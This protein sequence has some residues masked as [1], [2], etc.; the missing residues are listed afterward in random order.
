MIERLRH[1]LTLT[2]VLYFAVGVLCLASPSAQAVDLVPFVG[3]RFG[4]DV[5][6]TTQ[7]AQGPMSVTLDAAASYGGVIDVPLSGPRSI[8]FYY[9]RQQTTLGSPGVAQIHD[10]TM[11]VLHIGLV[12][13]YATDNPQLT[14][15][16]AGTF[17]ATQLTAAGSDETK[18]SIGLGGGVIWMANDHIGIR[19]DLRALLTF[20]GNG[21][22]AIACGGGC[23][24][25]FHGSLVAQG[26]ASV[27]LL[28]RF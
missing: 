7:G 25:S 8:E 22:G 11:S 15:L 6:T 27:G 4:G 13:A 26:E 16:L 9:S 5:G 28:V 12:D 21:G 2:G 19:G 1:V 24:I 3:F 14:W 20:S 17:G 10:V 18:P 23:S